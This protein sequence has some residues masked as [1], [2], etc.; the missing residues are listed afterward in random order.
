MLRSGI[1]AAYDSAY[2]PFHVMIHA[3]D[4]IAKQ[5]LYKYEKSGE[6][7]EKKYAGKFF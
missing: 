2:N 3:L 4:V 1:K 5:S 7:N 6:F